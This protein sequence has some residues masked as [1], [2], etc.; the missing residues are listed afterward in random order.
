MGK[1]GKIIGVTALLFVIA[2]VGLIVFVNFYLTE[3]RVKALVIPQAET[4]LGREVAIGDI[5][6]GFLS[7]ITI[8]DFIIKEADNE[9]NFISTKAFILSYDLMPLLQKKLVISEIRFDEP[10]VQIIRDKQGQFNFSTLA[11][12]STEGPQKEK[13]ERSATTAA[14]PLALTFN[15]I[16]FNQAQIRI[17]DQLNEIPA[18]DATTSAKLNITL[19]RTIKDLQ[20]NGSFDVDAAVEYGTARAKINGKGNINQKDFDIVLDKNVDGEQVHV[21]ANVKSYFQAPNATLNISSKSLNIDKIL[22]MAAGMPKAVS[23]TSK[24][25][26][27]KAGKSPEILA[28]SLPPGLVANGTVHVD[29]AL[30]KGI[31]TNDF[32]LVFNLSKGILTVKELSAQAYSGKLDS[33]LTVD[34]NQPGLAYNGSLGLQSVQADGLGSALVQKAAGMLTGSLQSAMNFSGAGT[35]WAELKN[36][37]NADGSFTLSDGGIKGTPVSSSISSLLGLQELNNIS[38][39]NLTGTFKIVEGGKVMVKSNLQ[40]ADLDAEAEG[41]IGLDGGLDLPLTLHLSPALTD[42]LKSRASFAKYLTDEQGGSTLH[43]KLTGNLTSPKPTLDMKGAKEQIQKSIQKEVFKQL[44]SSGQ[45]T[46]KK[47]SPENIIKGLFGR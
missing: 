24:T 7:G 47:E 34:L 25:V 44:D 5:K 23:D 9:N 2:V 36:V 40:G 37:L 19:G 1:L 39:K 13:K 29:K 28:D 43:F 32:A 21:E 45:E 22:A 17:R 20:Y 31:T 12:L 38:Y 6:I 35:S 16:N 27:T 14:L 18:V 41:I 46:D 33:N 42:K 15:Q 10:T 8:R 26:Q 3:E 11:L 4:A 30:Y